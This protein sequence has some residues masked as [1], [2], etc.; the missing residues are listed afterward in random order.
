[1]QGEEA[2]AVIRSDRSPYRRSAGALAMS[3]IALSPDSPMS[4]GEIPVVDQGRIEDVARRQSLLVEYL[5]LKGYDGLLLQDSA[6]FAW[7]TCGGSNFRQGNP[8]PTA[9]ALVTADA[10]VILCNNADSG[11]LFDRE[12]MGLGFLLKER[13]WTEDLSILRQDVCRGRKIASDSWVPG[14]EFVGADLT[15]FRRQLSE[16]EQNDLRKLG[17]QTAHAIEATGRNF[18]PGATET[19]IAGHLTHRLMKH[20]IQPVHLQVMADGQGWRYRHWSFGQDR[21][22]RHCVISVIGKRDGLHVGASRTICLGAPSTEM[23]EVHRLSTLV[24]STGMV[25]SQAGWSMQETWKRVSRIYEKFGVPDE[26]RCADQADL[27]GFRPSEGTLLPSSSQTF[28]SGMAVYWHPSVRSSLVTGTILIRE[29]GF[30]LLTPSQNWPSLS[31]RVKGITLD[32][33]GILI[34]EISPL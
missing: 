9:A 26:W 29:E 22:E 30:E 18:E 19:E 34:R 25:F 5:Q 31:I 11:Q 6:N 27:I 21:V 12:L 24:M 1:V 7:L 14:T 28:Q 23:Q 4:S 32:Q 8:V 15:A 20:Q 2:F 33:P 17:G 13:P 10:R 3:T 16:R